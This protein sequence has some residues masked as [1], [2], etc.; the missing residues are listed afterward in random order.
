MYKFVLI[1]VTHFERCKIIHKSRK[2]KENNEKMSSGI[3]LAIRNEE[4]GK[5]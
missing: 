5:S 4:L 1:L 2:N 3:K